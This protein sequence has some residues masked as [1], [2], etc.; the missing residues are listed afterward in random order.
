MA[1]APF[2][3]LA[4]VFRISS[5]RLL[6]RLCWRR[7]WLAGFVCNWGAIRTSQIDASCLSQSNFPTKFGKFAFANSGRQINGAEDKL[8]CVAEL[9]LGTVRIGSCRLAETIRPHGIQVYRR[10]GKS[11]SLS[12]SEWTAWVR[13][14]WEAGWRLEIIEFRHQRFQ[15]N[16]GGQSKAASGSFLCN[17]SPI[18]REFFFRTGLWKTN[19]E[20][21]SALTAK[22][23]S[24]RAW[25]EG[26]LAVKWEAAGQNQ[27]KIPVAEM[28]ARQLELRILRGLAPFRL[29]LEERIIPP[30]NAHSIDPFIVDEI[31]GDERLEIILAGKNL[32]YR[33]RNGGG[34]KAEPLCVFPPYLIST[35]L[36]ADFTFTGDGFADLLCMKR[37][38]ACFASRSAWRAF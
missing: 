3:V 34:Y 29:V 14:F 38:R 7:F 4:V 12:P 5:R 27:G 30:E 35:A 1:L 2:N 20:N 13:R 32:V 16:F 23:S 6:P 21:P 26:T 17:L 9:N 15:V 18:R 19:P 8:A 25:I 36:L 33:D 31:Y 22:T 37:P 24:R 11:F 10:A 28:D